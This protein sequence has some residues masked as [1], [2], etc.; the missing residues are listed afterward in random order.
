[1]KKKNIIGNINSFSIPV[2]IFLS[3]AV[4]YQIHRWSWGAIFPSRLFTCALFFILLIIFSFKIW[5]WMGFN[6]KDIIN[7]FDKKWIYVSVLAVLLMLSVWIGRSFFPGDYNIHKQFTLQLLNGSTEGHFFYRETPGH[8]P[9]LAHATLATFVNLTGLRMHHIFLAVSALI[10]FFIP[11]FSYKLARQLNFS[12]GLSL[13]FSSLISLYG[14]FVLTMRRMF[15]LYLP[16]NQISMPFISRNI[17]LLL[18][19]LFL[20]ISYKI[21]QTQNSSYKLSINLG[22]LIGLLGLTHP[23]AFMSAI[24][25]LSVIYV[26]SFKRKCFTKKIILHFIVSI[27]IGFVMASVYYIPMIIKIIKYGGL[28]GVKAEE[29]FPLSL[30]LYGPLLFLGIYAFCNKKNLKSW[31]LPAL[32][33]LI[34]IVFGRFIL[35][36]AI[37]IK[38]WHVFRIHRYG[39]YLFIF[40]ALFATAGI[41]NLLRFRKSIRRAAVAI[42]IFTI[43]TGYTTAFIYLDSWRNIRIGKIIKEF[44]FA[45][46][47]PERGIEQLR[48]YISNPKNTLIVPP[49]I[50]R[51]IAYETGLNIPYTEKHR[52]LFKDFFKKNISQEERLKMVNDFYQDLEKGILREDI[53]S[54]FATDIFLSSKINL[55]KIYK[56]KNI[57]SVKINNKEWFLYQLTTSS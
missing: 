34:I 4:I 31:M 54:T 57:T 19:L 48:F 42:I 56:L 6:S 41:D 1:M 29:M 21:Y 53:L 49:K 3:I 23:Q 22:I 24:L 12:W 13:F 30:W 52:I 40:L 25:F 45:N 47:F 37:S 11:L 5:P 50:A 33:T 15:H 35:G 8:Y 16:A 43:L 32:L 10:A 28:T 55:E 26:S 36:L 2:V 18:F 51:R 17:A 20:I 9:P 14:G 27:F 46:I 38:R 44:K 7:T 39:P